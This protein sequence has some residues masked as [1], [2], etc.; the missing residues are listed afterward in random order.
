MCRKWQKCD[1]NWIYVSDS[2]ADGVG[3]RGNSTVLSITENV[4]LIIVSYSTRKVAA[5]KRD[6]MLQKIYIGSL[7]SAFA[8]SI[9]SIPFASHG[10][11][12]PS[13][14]TEKS[15]VYSD[16]EFWFTHILKHWNS[17][18][19]SETLKQFESFWNVETVWNILKHW[20]NL[21][22]SETLNQFDTFWNVETI[23]NI[24]KR[25]TSFDTFRNFK[26]VWHIF[27]RWNSLKHFEQFVQS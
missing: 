19:H 12:S 22:H 2:S 16:D 6:S 23:W 8:P 5:I 27:K 14:W 10:L 21:K 4:A 17:L 18:K 20:K 25:W 11:V 15:V 3:G 1:A 26:T 7:A 24:F 13:R 9:R